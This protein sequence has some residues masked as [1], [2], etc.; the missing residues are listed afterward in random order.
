[1]NSVRQSDCFLVVNGPEDGTEFPIAR[2]PF[3]IGA[4]STCVVNPRLD[5]A[6]AEQHGMVSVVSEGYVIRSVKNA[7][8]FV[9]GRKV[10][11][12]RS[13][14]VRPG[15][16]LQVGNTLLCLECVPDGLSS[17][18]HGVGSISD[19]RFALRLVFETLWSVLLSVYNLIVALINRSFSFAGFVFIAGILLYVYWDYASSYL[20]GS[21]QSVIREIFTFLNNVAPGK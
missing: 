21:I 15:S 7:R 8:I 9:D 19:L 13:R 3:Y 12:L 11:A 10:G 4:D 17:R 6:I 16:Y 14:V 20:F 5:S 18:S 2:S 1:V